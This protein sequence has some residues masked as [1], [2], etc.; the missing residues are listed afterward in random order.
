[1]PRHIFDPLPHSSLQPIS[2]LASLLASLHDDDALLFSFLLSRRA[3]SMQRCLPSNVGTSSAPRG[4]FH[5]FLPLKMLLIMS[6]GDTNQSCVRHVAS[7]CMAVSA[8]FLF[9]VDSCR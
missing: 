3:G 6:T 4:I 1:M 9:G 8:L 7:A 5:F 2:L